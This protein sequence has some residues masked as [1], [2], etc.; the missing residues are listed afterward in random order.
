MLK[1]R[2]AVGLVVRGALTRCTVKN[3]LEFLQCVV[4]SAVWVKFD[5][6]IERRNLDL[7][8]TLNEN[9]ENT[10]KIRAWGVLYHVMIVIA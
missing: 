8:S 7:K 4:Q 2:K 5:L 3:M 9:K 10:Q 1:S 6:M